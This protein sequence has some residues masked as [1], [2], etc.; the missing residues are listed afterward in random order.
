MTKKKIKYSYDNKTGIVQM[1]V[2][3]PEKDGK[4]IWN[5][6]GEDRYVVTYVFAGT[7]K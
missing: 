7:K 3:N 1:E 6:S 2:Q 4:V 5:K